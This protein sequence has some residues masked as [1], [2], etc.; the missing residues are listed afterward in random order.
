[1]ALAVCLAISFLLSGMEAGVFALSRLRIRQYMRAGDAQAR[2][3][4]GYLDDSEDFLWTILVGNTLANFLAVAIVV[5]TL[6]SWFGEWPAV[7]CLALLVVAF[8]FYMLC[9]LLPKMLFRAFPNRLCLVMARP[10]R[11]IHALLRPLVGLVSWLSQGL[12]R[13]TG[14]R[15]FTGHLFGNR[16]ELR[17]V[18]QESGEG[19]STEERQMINRVMDLQ[20]AT[21]RQILV[22]LNQVVTVDAASTA[23]QVRAIFGERRLAV[24]PVLREEAGRKRVIGIVTLK[25]L[26]TLDDLT[27]QTALNLLRPALY[28]DEKTRWENALR[29]MQRGG[30]RLAIVLGPDRHEI[31]IVTLQDLLKPLFGEINL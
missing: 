6:F 27:G 1:M 17:L 22:P 11:A 20:S 14:T 10:F 4:H 13:W 3:L 24:L 23:A 29:L 25:H 18:M 15:V 21:I 28:L 16:E 5:T 7:F 12:V 19:L 30:H 26:L 8:L 9:D 2:I 31:G